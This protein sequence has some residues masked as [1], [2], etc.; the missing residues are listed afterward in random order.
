MIKE[1]KK[2]SKYNYKQTKQQIILGYLKT[3]C[4]SILFSIILTTCLAINARNEMLKDVSLEAEKQNII[5][6]ATAQ[7]LI[8]QTN[9]LKDLQYKKYSVCLHVGKLQNI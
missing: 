8:T 6:K 3:I 9:L 2:K 4:Y 7:K 5:D 1:K